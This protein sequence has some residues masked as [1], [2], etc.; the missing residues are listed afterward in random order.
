MITELYGDIF[1][2]SYYSVNRNAGL[3]HLSVVLKRSESNLD[4]CLPL[5]IES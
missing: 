4:L 2:Y 3:F 5:E 1:L